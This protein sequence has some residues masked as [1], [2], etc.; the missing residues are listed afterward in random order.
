MVYIFA[1][2]QWGSVAPG[3]GKFTVDA[4][5]HTVFPV[6]ESILDKHIE[7]LWSEGICFRARLFTALRG[8]LLDNLGTEAQHVA[9]AAAAD[10]DC[11]AFAFDNRQLC[12]V[13]ALL[14][15]A[16]RGLE[17]GQVGRGGCLLGKFFN[18][19]GERCQPFGQLVNFLD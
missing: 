3:H 18:R 11:A 16:K 14:Q 5:R 7:T 13:R 10:D 9:A 8:M 12:G 19:G 17:L 2:L 4:D 6:M 15:V 1:P